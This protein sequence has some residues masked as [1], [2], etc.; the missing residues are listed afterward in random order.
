MNINPTLLDE[1]VNKFEEE[2]DVRATH[3]DMKVF[4]GN[5]HHKAVAFYKPK[6]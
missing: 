2:N 4:E 3:T 5:L 1:A 6:K